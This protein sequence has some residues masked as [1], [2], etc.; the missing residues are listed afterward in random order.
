[1]SWMW[2]G[3]EVTMGGNIRSRYFDI[4]SVTH[5]WA[6]TIGRPGLLGALIWRESNWCEK[7]HGLGSK[8]SVDSE[9]FGRMQ[10][11]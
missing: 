11:G 7:G 8:Q 10:R 1:M 4:N 5:L 2:E 9:S 6:Q 3:K